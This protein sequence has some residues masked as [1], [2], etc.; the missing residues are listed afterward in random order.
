MSLEVREGGIT[1]VWVKKLQEF[2]NKEGFEGV[3]GVV[4]RG[5]K[6]EE[7]LSK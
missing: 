5:E 7:T 3:L 2:Y 4:C 1:P 6:F